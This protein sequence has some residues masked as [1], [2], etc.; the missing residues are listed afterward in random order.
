MSTSCL[1]PHVARISDWFLL[2]ILYILGCADVARRGQS[3]HLC[4]APR[5]LCSLL[6]RV[7]HVNCLHKFKDA[8]CYKK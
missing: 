3:R 8:E 5:Q 4:T 1:Y 6:N 2:V 7:I